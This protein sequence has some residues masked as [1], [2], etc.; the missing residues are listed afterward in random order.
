M[1][2][3][4]ILDSIYIIPILLQ[5]IEEPNEN[6]RAFLHEHGITEDMISKSMSPA[7]RKQAGPGVIFPL[8][9]LKPLL[10][11]HLEFIRNGNPPYDLLRMGLNQYFDQYLFKCFQLLGEVNQKVLML[12]LGSGDGSYADQF[13]RDNPESQVICVDKAHTNAFKR[14]GKQI[15]TVDFE[16]DPEWYHMFVNTFD[17][18]L[19][20]ELLHCKTERGQSE[21]IAQALTMTKKF[22]KIIINENE[23]YAMAY[24]ISQIKHK[25]HYIIDLDRVTTL[26]RDRAV[27]RKTITINKHTF[28]VFQKL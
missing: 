12:D 26:M 14:L 21:I 15:H 28:Y 8:M 4:E 25:P 23:D 9:E 1:T 11:Y 5:H 19:I 6:T 27:L 18:V 24:R 20:S 7:V 22:G 2:V 10:E 3:Q 17:R 16:K 13:L